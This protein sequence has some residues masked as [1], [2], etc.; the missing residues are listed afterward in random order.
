MTVCS[1]QRFF[2]HL[3][4]HSC[5]HSLFEKAKTLTNSKYDGVYW[6]LITRLYEKKFVNEIKIMD[7]QTKT[8]RTFDKFHKI[9]KSFCYVICLLHTQTHTH[10]YICMQHISK[11]KLSYT[12]E[13][14][15][16]ALY[17]YIYLLHIICAEHIVGAQKLNR[18]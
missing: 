14:R 12:K 4:F 3:I 7:R 11:M 16:H 17:I 18:V 6:T 5:C 2:Y 1:D 15:Y 8:R 13:G 9:E 10:T